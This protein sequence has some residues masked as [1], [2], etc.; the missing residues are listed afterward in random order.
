MIYFADLHVHSKFS[1]ATSK[2]N[3]LTHLAYWASV[4]GLD[5][6]ATGD[7]THPLW[8]NQII[9]DLE[10]DEHGLY[11]LRNKLSH[12]LELPF[13]KHDVCAARFILNVEISSIYKKNGR[14]RKIH[15]LVFMPDL[16]SM[17]RFCSKLERV[18]NLNS[19]GR[20]I[21][22]LDCKNLLEIALESSPYSFLI[23][24][25]IWTPWFS[26]LG[27]NSGFDSVEECFEDLTGYIFALETGLSSDPDMN[28]RISFLDEYTLVSNSDTHSPSKLGREVNIFSGTPSYQSI[29][30]SLKRGG[31]GCER[32]KD[33]ATPRAT[34]MA[35][36]RFDENVDRFWGTIEFFPEEGK[37]HWDGHRRCGV[38]ID[39]RSKIHSNDKICPV[40]GQHL[41]IGVLNRVIAL[42][43]RPIAAVGPKSGLFWRMAP[44]MEVISNAIGSG[45]GSKKVLEIY[46][47]MVNKL[48][49]ELQILWAYDS[50]TL[51]KLTPARVLDAIQMM[52]TGVVKIEPGFDGVYGKVTIEQRSNGNSA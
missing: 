47:T 10:E 6:L 26:L 19:D 31:P 8:R 28:R 5:V 1:R 37:Y 29:M 32:T 21:L 41:T 2:D 35:S 42:S 7:F 11:R 22:G 27:A 15:N 25:H 38:R 44:L 24:A 13:G 12:S 20:P 39:P 17:I 40:C 34:L 16:S 48:G 9:E 50:D 33:L 45:P 36:D 46:K 52:R 23:P 18:G 30:E 51:A 4:K 3:D 14:V 49:P 43:D